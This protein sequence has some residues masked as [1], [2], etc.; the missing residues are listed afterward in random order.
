MNK[1]YQKVAEA[2]YHSRRPAWTATL[3]VQ[4]LVADLVASNR[5]WAL[6]G[7]VSR[8]YQS[9]FLPYQLTINSSARQGIT[10]SQDRTVNVLVVGLQLLGSIRCVQTR[11]FWLQTRAL[12]RKM[13]QS[14][15]KSQTTGAERW[16]GVGKNERR[17]ERSG[18]R[19][20]QKWASTRS[21]KTARLSVPLDLKVRLL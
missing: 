11:I 21:G 5:M 12:E 3:L 7:H 6:F 18:E 20:S 10:Y 17:A 14:G 4:N 9:P 19:R 16:V 15:P 2:Q 8:L 1:D 13:E